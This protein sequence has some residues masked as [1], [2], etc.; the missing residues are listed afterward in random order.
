[1]IV[2]FTVV[3][4]KKAYTPI[5]LLAMALHRLPMAM[6]KGC[7]F[8]KLLGS[9]KNGTFD[10]SPDWQQWGLL[11]VW[12]SRDDYER[13]KENSFITKWWKRFCV[14]TWTVLCTPHQSHG[15]WDG[16][17]PFQTAVPDLTY[18]GPI[19]VLTR[20]TIRFNKLKNFWSHV[21]EVAELMAKAPGYIMSVGIGEAPVYK[22]ATFSVWISSEA[23]KAFAYKSNE[24]KDVIRKT[25]QEN[26][27]SEALFARFKPIAA[28]GTINGKNPLE[29]II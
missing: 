11:A 18:T 24:H 5:A 9:G 4:Y 3:R 25:H 6:Q 13:F 23:M 20:A 16:K 21:D 12:D 19:A 14:E 28:F 17:E 15:V 1:M 10:L 22:Q 29:N 26:W 27:Y 7:T 8:W 2:S